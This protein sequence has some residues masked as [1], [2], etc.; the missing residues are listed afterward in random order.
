MQLSLSSLL[1]KKMDDHQF[2][3]LLEFFNRS[4]KGYRKVRKGVKKRIG[5][6]MQSVGCRQMDAYLHLLKTSEAARRACERLLTVSISRFYRDRQIWQLLSMN[7]LPNLARQNDNPVR[8]WSAGC[9]RGEEVYSL[10]IAWEE[11]KRRSTRAGRLTIVA[12]DLNADYLAMA[13]NGHYT[14]GSVKELSAE[15]QTRYFQKSRSGRRLS[16]RPELKTGI[17]WICQ[18]LLNGPPPEK[19]YDLILLRNNLLT[20]YRAP[21]VNTGFQNVMA[22]LAPAGFLIIGAHEH[23]PDSA[24]QLTPVVGSKLIYR[25]QA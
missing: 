22:A 18:D 9:A 3:L 24:T 14:R 23:L 6:H 15:L 7:I 2:K 4:W 21:D 11:L 16:V 10:K 19:K 5:R 17:E 1:K 20:Y 13:R 25:R 8:I 12:S